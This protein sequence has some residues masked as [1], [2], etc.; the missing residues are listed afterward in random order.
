MAATS[1]HAPLQRKP[2]ESVRPARACAILGISRR[3][4]RE[5]VR[6]KHLEAVGDGH[7]KRITVSSLAGELDRRKAEVDFRISALNALKFEK[8]G[9]LWKVTEEKTK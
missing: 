6:K 1:P 3:W 8:G 5:L 9:S 4:L 7:G 2:L